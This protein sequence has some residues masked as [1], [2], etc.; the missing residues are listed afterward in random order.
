LT[1]VDTNVD[2]NPASPTFG[3]LTGE[4]LASQSQLNGIGSSGTIGL[5]LANDEPFVLSLLPAWNS[6]T[7]EGNAVS[8][9]VPI[10]GI[11][12][13]NTVVSP[14]SGIFEGNFTTLPDD[15]EMITASFDL[16]TNF[17]P[18]DG[19]IS[20]VGVSELASI[21]EPSSL[22]LFS[23]AIVASLFAAGAGGGMALSRP[24]LKLH[25]TICPTAQSS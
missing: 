7:L 16:T 22:I 13:F 15:Q 14:F 6:P 5:M 20:A 18:A 24:K 21:P 11:A 2:Y 4:V 23:T 10:T 1:T 17:G 8:F 25:L 12:T 3:N 19:L 9:S